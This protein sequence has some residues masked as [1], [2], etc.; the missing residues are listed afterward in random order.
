M[1]ELLV[2]ALTVI[3]PDESVR[4]QLMAAALGSALV[5]RSVALLWSGI[6]SAV[7]SDDITSMARSGSVFLRLVDEFNGGLLVARLE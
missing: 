5:H 3:Q 6:V 4:T 7:D 1:D 2:E